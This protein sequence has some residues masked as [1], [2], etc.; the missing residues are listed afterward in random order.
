MEEV[1][2]EVVPLQLLVEVVVEAL[3]LNPPRKRRRK[4]QRSVSYKALLSLLS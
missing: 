3:P 2:V 4:N 1:V